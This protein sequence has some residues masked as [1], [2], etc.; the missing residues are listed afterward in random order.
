VGASRISRRKGAEQREQILDRAGKVARA[1]GGLL[2]IGRVSGA[3][4]EGLETIEA[5]LW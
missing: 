1:S 2:G 5:L 4:S 3:E